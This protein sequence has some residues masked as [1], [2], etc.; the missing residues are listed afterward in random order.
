MEIGKG[1][2]FRSW[3]REDLGKGTWGSLFSIRCYRYVFI[4]GFQIAFLINTPISGSPGRSSPPRKTIRAA[5]AG[6]CQKTASSQ[7]PGLA[8]KPASQ[9]TS[10]EG[11]RPL[12]PNWECGPLSA[13]R[14][15]RPNISIQHGQ[16]Q[17]Q[18]LLASKNTF[19]GTAFRRVFS[20]GPHCTVGSV[21]RGPP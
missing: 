13:C 21:T 12:Q 19:P 10:Q 17:Q 8:R 9:P 6:P 20:Y 14:S 5:S 2:V 11:S 4:K 16:E 7:Q 1:V 15:G 3:R 18:K